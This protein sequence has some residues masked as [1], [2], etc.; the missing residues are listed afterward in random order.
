M[1]FDRYN[2]KEMPHVTVQKFITLNFLRTILQ[3]TYAHI[4]YAK[5]ISL[6]AS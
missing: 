1:I 4:Y 3:I 2:H 6:M 5:N